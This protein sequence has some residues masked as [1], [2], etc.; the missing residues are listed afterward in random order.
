M[1]LLIEQADP[2]TRVY[3]AV[4]DRH[5]REH[6][7]VDFGT[8]V[9]KGS[10]LVGGDNPVHATT[11]GTLERTVLRPSSR[12]N[13]EPAL[14]LS[15]RSDGK[16][17]W[18][19]RA[20]NLSPLTQSAEALLT[21]IA[22]AGIVGLGGGAFPTATKLATAIRHTPR[23][24]IVNGVECEPGVQ[25]DEALMHAASVEILQG[26]LLA[27]QI[28]NLDQCILAIGEDKHSALEI[29]TQ[30]I[31]QQELSGKIQL[32]P[33]ADKFPNGSE[34]QL[35]KICTG[36]ALPRNVYPAQLGISVLNVST[37]YAIYQAIYL[38]QALVERVV[39]LHTPQSAKNI[40][41]HIGT[42]AKDLVNNN[43]PSRANAPAVS[44]NLIQR[45]GPLT[46]WIQSIDACVEKGTTCLQLIKNTVPKPALPCI[47][48]GKCATICPE[49]LLP[50]ELYWYSKPLNEAKLN[51][52]KLTSCLTCG[53][54]ETVCPSQIPLTNMFRDSQTLLKQYAAHKQQARQVSARV[55]ARTVR[56][57]KSGQSTQSQRE[58]RLSRL[59]QSRSSN[60]EQ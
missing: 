13:A 58:K 19:P 4:Q 60:H 39:T 18:L 48:C 24:L 42:P 14:H 11:S 55:K 5:W 32:L 41:V 23:Y 29:F 17:Q 35:I 7:Q 53:L 2:P 59:R 47:R 46:G 25:A 36:T 31:L 43:F 8:Y 3:L 15:I 20:K 52:L 51:A 37:L 56:L 26:A 38:D 27:L 28:L 30:K 6:G 1:N 9:L 22:T 21:K 57:E 33:V 44:T 40:R 34:R 45:G 50:Q 49:N 12:K 54:C 10:L 16:D